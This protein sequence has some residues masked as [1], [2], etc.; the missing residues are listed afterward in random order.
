MAWRYPGGKIKLR[1]AQ[2]GSEIMTISAHPE[3]IISVAFSPSGKRIVST[4]VD[5]TI[6]SWDVHEGLE[7]MT[8]R[9]HEDMVFSALFSL[10]GT[11]LFSSSRDG[12]GRVWELNNQESD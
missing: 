6:K 4:G 3:R 10:D 11:K 5:K 8:L 7:I 12:T 2:D 9:G 1:N